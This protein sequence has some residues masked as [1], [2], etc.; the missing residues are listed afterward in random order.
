MTTTI[1]HASAPYS[2]W[3]TASTMAPLGKMVPGVNGLEYADALFACTWT[4]TLSMLLLPPPPALLVV[5]S[6]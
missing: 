5:V 6:C 2:S 4:C 1:G 3:T